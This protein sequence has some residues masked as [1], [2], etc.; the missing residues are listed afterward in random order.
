MAIYNR[1]G[2]YNHSWALKQGRMVAV[3]NSFLKD[4]MNKV[5]VSLRNPPMN[6]TPDNTIKVVIMP[7]ME[8]FNPSNASATR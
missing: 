3:A 1:P 8:D 4:G 2:M 7:K 6:G 5:N